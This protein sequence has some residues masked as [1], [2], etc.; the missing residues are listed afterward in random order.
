MYVTSWRHVDGVCISL[1]IYVY[2]MGSLGF[3][4]RTCDI[5]WQQIFA[6]HSQINT[7]GISG[8]TPYWQSVLHPCKY[9]ISTSSVLLDLTSVGSLFMAYHNIL[10]DPEARS[11]VHGPMT[12]LLSNTP[13]SSLLE[14]LSNWT[15]I[16]FRQEGTWWPGMT[17][18]VIGSE[19]LHCSGYKG[20]PLSIC[21]I[22]MGI[23]SVCTIS[24]MTIWYLYASD[25]NNVKINKYNVKGYIFNYSINSFFLFRKIMSKCI[26]IGL[27]FII[28]SETLHCSGYK[29]F[30]LSIC[31]IDMGISS[32]CT[33]SVMTIWYLYASDLNNVKINKYNV[34][35]YIF[36]YSINSCFLFRK[37]MSKCIAI[38]LS[39]IIWKFVYVDWIM[40]DQVWH[41]RLVW[42]NVDWIMNDQVWHHRLV[43]LNVD[44][45]MNDQV[46]HPRLVWLN[47]DWIM[48]DQV[49][50][51]RLVWLLCLGLIS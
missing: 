42:L 36:N 13:D 47:V 33:I 20:F 39:F 40:N 46:W 51:P 38:G 30:P 1:Y 49:W 28:W 4:T 12:R 26:A 19:T 3:D 8:I 43:W 17:L 32:V 35:G 34:K 15:S 48:N 7:C 9:L 25:L 37:I 18:F 31:H 45:I 24:V 41:P 21:H 22:D 2:T 50:H 5:C 10:L 44:W 29:G 27:N 11:F 16:R 14:C 6:Y 23:S